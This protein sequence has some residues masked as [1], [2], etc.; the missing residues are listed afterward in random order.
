MMTTIPTPVIKKS[1]YLKFAGTLML[2]NIGKLIT[3]IVSIISFAFAG[4][5]GDRQNT[6]TI[7][8]HNTIVIGKDTT[9][10]YLY[11][12]DGV[13][14]CISFESAKEILPNSTIVYNV[15]NPL[16]L[17]LWVL[18]AI[19][20]IA[21]I[22]G[23]LSS[24]ESGWEFRENW[25]EMIR[26]EVKVVEE[27]GLFKWFVMNKLIYSSKELTDTYRITHIIDDFIN[28]G[29]LYPDFTSKQDKRSNK[30]TKLGI[31]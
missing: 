17:L 27:D 28:N 21:L 1:I 11:L 16:N 7:I 30:L 18:F 20:L 31:K 29:N 24:D 23:T 3:L 5:F 6:E 14:R 26:S 15:Y 12:S 2:K 4:S 19:G 9:Y 13:I 22:V 10:T 25:K 8:G